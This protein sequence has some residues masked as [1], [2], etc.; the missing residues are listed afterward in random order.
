[1]GKDA[2][3]LCQT[4]IQLYRSGGSQSKYFKVSNQKVISAASQKIHTHYTKWFTVRKTKTASTANPNNI[5]LKDKMLFY[6]LKDK[7]LFFL[8]IKS[9]FSN[10]YIYIYNHYSIKKKT[11]IFVFYLPQNNSGGGCRVL[12]RSKKSYS[13]VIRSQSATVKDRIV[14]HWRMVRFRLFCLCSQ[15]LTSGVVID[16]NWLTCWANSY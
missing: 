9:A 3:L 11:M 4:G 12:I 16:K 1:M 6:L 13:A 5:L 8:V 14:L 10:I 7:M 15:Y 2:A